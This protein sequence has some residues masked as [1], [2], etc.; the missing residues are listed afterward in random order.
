MKR[1]LKILGVVAG[2]AATA[3]FVVYAYHALHG[4]D[5]SALLR[6]QVVLALCLLTLLYTALIPVTAVAWSLLLRGLGRHAPVAM[7]APILASSQFGK[8]LPGNVAHHVGRLVMAR[9]AGIGTGRCILSIAYESVLTVLACAHVSAL[10]FLWDT[11]KA[12]ADSTITDNRGLLIMLVTAGAIAT[13]ML[14]PR[15]AQIV[16][17]LRNRHSPET[18]PPSLSPGAAALAI[19]YLCYAANF[20]LVGFGLWIVASVLVPGTGVSPILLTGAFASSWLI[21]FVTPGAP[22]G[23]GVREAVLTFWLNESLPAESVVVLVLALRI[24]TTLGDLINLAWG[25]L[26]LRLRHPSVGSYEP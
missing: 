17:R 25:S 13:L 20:A 9:S 3:F 11:P 16:W 2:L 23:L 26:A 22:A 19:G 6:P 24:A 18:Q 21:G 7:T 8:Y 10:T 14:A 4:Q 12:F 5:L 15:L 1:W